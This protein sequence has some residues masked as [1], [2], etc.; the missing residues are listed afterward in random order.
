M[1]SAEENLLRMDSA[2]EMRA[3]GSAKVFNKNVF[4]HVAKV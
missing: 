1:D 2:E 4:P 3:S